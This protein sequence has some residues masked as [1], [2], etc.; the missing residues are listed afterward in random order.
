MGAPSKF[1]HPDKH[2]STSSPQ[3]PKIVYLLLIAQMI[4]IGY[5]YVYVNCHFSKLEKTTQELKD[6][7]MQQNTQN[8]LGKLLSPSDRLKRDT[9][10][11][12]K[13]SNYF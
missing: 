9:D 10:Q 3:L 1:S 13:V 2:G 11:S 7:L 5:G 12:A 6:Q 4:L 8:N